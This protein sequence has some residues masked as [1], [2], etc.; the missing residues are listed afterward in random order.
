[1]AK[2]F[3]NLDRLK[4]SPRPTIVLPDATIDQG[5]ATLIKTNF[6][7][8]ISLSDR[9]KQTKLGTTRHLPEFFLSDLFTGVITIKKYEPF[10]HTSNIK[11]VYPS[12]TVDQGS[13]TIKLIKFLPTQGGTNPTFV[14]LNSLNLQ[15]TIFSNGVYTSVI[16]ITYPI[17][18]DRIQHGS[19]VIKLSLIHI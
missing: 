13:A 1:M 8:T 9:L 7:N 4:N 6:A 5:R 19:V 3:A 10:Q 16:T 11:I 14:T 2:L 15:G 17:G 18:V 12:A